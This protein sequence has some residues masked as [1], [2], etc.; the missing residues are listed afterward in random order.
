MLNEM[1]LD[2][3]DVAERQSALLGRI[4]KQNG[5]AVDT[6]RQAAA[7]SAAVSSKSPAVKRTKYAIDIKNHLGR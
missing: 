4:H 3:V 7:L 5:E 2:H 1:S 6:K